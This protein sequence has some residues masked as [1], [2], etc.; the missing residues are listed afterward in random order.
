MPD[1]EQGGPVDLLQVAR[2][3]NLKVDPDPAGVNNQTNQQIRSFRARLKELMENYI[4][5]PDFDV[6]SLVL[7]LASD[8]TNNWQQ[9]YADIER[10]RIKNTTPPPEQLSPQKISVVGGFTERVDASEE[11]LEY[12]RRISSANLTTHHEVLIIALTSNLPPATKDQ[13]IPTL[14]QAV[15]NG[16]YDCAAKDV[17]LEKH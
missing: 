3:L 4:F 16:K 17:S 2:D 11:A 12:A 13:W 15:L 14:V 10:F 5:P 9:T 6:R 8:E 7:A 1:S